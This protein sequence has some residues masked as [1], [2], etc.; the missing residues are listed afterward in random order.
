MTGPKGLARPRLAALFAAALAAASLTAAGGAAPPRAAGPRI[1][2]LASNRALL[3]LYALESR[4]ARAQAQLADATARLDA[5]ERR[6]RATRAQLA[7]AEATLNRAQGLLASRLRDLYMAGEPDPLAIVLGASSL[8]EMVAGIDDLRRAASQNQTTIAQTRRAR[9]TLRRLTVELGTREARL[10]GLRATA[11]A[12]AASLQAAVSERRTYL[13][14]LRAKDRLA[15]AQVTALDRQAKGV[16]ARA[17]QVTANA[18]GALSPAQASAVVSAGSE[19]GW[20]ARTLTVSAT[21]YS[22]RGRTATGAPT[23][24]GVVAVDPGVIPLGTRM[25]IPGYGEG[26]AADTGGAVRGAT[27]DLW[28]ATA[29]QAQA[30]GRRTVTITLH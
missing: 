30:W 9:R 3:E 11:A 6:Q 17:Q 21:G 13:A 19:T 24:P 26:V 5:L 25:T 4:L 15:A 12:G 8:D 20:T 22:I 10:E 23:G 29:A 18:P 2:S 16:Q 7:F 14:R 27:I 28:F 1:A